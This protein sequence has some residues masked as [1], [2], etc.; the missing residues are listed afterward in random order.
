MSDG[1]QIPN[2]TAEVLIFSSQ[3]A[4]GGLK[5]RYETDK[6]FLNILKKI[7]GSA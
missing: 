1:K 3:S 7:G 6:A 2:S 5:V 4:G